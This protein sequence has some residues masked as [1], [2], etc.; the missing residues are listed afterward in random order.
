MLSISDDNFQNLNTLK[1]VIECP[2][3]YLINYFDDIKSRIDAK[4]VSILSKVAD[5]DF[6]NETIK[7]WSKL[8]GLVDKCL[9]KCFNNKL[10]NE[11]VKEADE[12]IFQSDLSSTNEIQRVK[13]KLLS[14]LLSND[15]YLVI[16]VNL[17]KHQMLK[18][19]ILIVEEKFTPSETE[20]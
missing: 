5:L 2:K 17:E 15:C 8:I 12:L 7:K 10:P 20:W 14:H 13:N 4:F 9:E 18:E 3:L 19:N 11:L 1:Q 16:L 6:K